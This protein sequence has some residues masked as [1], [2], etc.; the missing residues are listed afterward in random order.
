MGDPRDGF[1]IVAEFDSYTDDYPVG[2]RYGGGVWIG[3]L[4]FGNKRSDEWDGPFTDYD[5][6]DP[7]TDD[8]FLLQGP[9]FIGRHWW[10][11]GTIDYYMYDAATDY[12]ARLW[13]S[14][15]LTTWHESDL[16]AY[17]IGP[18]PTSLSPSGSSPG[19][20]QMAR[21][22]D[23][24]MYDPATDAYALLLYSRPLFD[25]A[26]LG[27]GARIATTF[28]PADGWTIGT[29]SA[30]VHPD[31]S[32][33]FAREFKVVDAL[34]QAFPRIGDER[35]QFIFESMWRA[36]TAEDTT[37]ATLLATASDPEGPWTYTVIGTWVFE[38]SGDI[39][40]SWVFPE[41]IYIISS[42]IW[43]NGS[44]WL[45]RSNADLNYYYS[46][47]G[48]DGS[49]AQLDNVLDVAV[50]DGLWFVSF[51]DYD[52]SGPLRYVVAAGTSLASLET[53][54]MPSVL[55]GGYLETWRAGPGEWLAYYASET[56]TGAVRAYYARPIGS[57]SG[58]GG[59]WGIILS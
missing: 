48:I 3:N 59:G 40:G 5:Y 4:N 10:M 33:G 47:D 50:G 32:E 12:N 45:I 30:F 52:E 25:Y 57:G 7:E 56:E 6:P 46:S 43:N 34:G 36:P 55:L 41:Y 26:Y 29:T 9:L 38:S 18:A 42:R 21:R 19:Q 44:E 15:D 35:Y 53:V 2:V 31:E 39:S 8:F 54:S 23:F 49:W 24:P 16:S 17:E 11:S 27:S 51:A 13:W 14:D 20:W 22:C 37:V 1:E 58:G 28:D